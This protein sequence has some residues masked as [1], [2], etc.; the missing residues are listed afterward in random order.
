MIKF[1]TTLLSK[2][3]PVPDPSH[4]GVVAHVIDF[5]AYRQKR[6][7]VAFRYKHLS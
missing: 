3:S 6:G 1:F 5:E 7:I 4:M 2:F